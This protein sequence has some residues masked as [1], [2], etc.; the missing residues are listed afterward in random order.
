LGNNPDSEPGTALRDLSAVLPREIAVW[1]DAVKPLDPEH[2]G[3]FR[4]AE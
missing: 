4:S 1:V 2:A 3:F